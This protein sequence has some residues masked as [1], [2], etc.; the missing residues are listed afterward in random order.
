M[1]ECCLRRRRFLSWSADHQPKLLETLAFEDALCRGGIKAL[2]PGD[3]LTHEDNDRIAREGDGR[4]P[5]YEVEQSSETDLLINKTSK[6][7]YAGV[8]VGWLLSL[9]VPRAKSLLEV[10]ACLRS[11]FSSWLKPTS[12]AKPGGR[13]PG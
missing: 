10:A 11:L 1:R 8:G 3:R 4:R 13:C 12:Q 7:V 2:R 6:A 5:D 9:T